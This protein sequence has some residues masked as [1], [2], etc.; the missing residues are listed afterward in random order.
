MAE[1][2]GEIPV[3]DLD[4]NLHGANRQQLVA[5]EDLGSNS[6]YFLCQRGYVCTL[7]IKLITMQTSTYFRRML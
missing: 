6:R 4:N 7:V 3:A 5:W 1:P 2:S